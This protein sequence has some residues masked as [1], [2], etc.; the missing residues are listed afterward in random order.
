MNNSPFPTVAISARIKA[1]IPNSVWNV[2]IICVLATSCVD[3]GAGGDGLH[4]DASALH[5]I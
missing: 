4:M 3:G 1:A 2:R 5:C